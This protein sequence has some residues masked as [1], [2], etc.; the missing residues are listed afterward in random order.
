MIEQRRFVAALALACSILA[1]CD[2]QAAEGTKA[3]GEVLEGTVSD[4]MIAT[5]Q[6]RSEPPLA[7]HIVEAKDAG[8][9]G[10]KPKATS[11]A[12][13]AAPTTSASEP[14]EASP[15]AK[16]AAKPADSEPTG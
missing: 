6:I 16:P 11:S 12:K 7:P 14:A 15:A 8:D 1:G 3:T 2:R 4:A 5:E 9:D 10:A 13:K